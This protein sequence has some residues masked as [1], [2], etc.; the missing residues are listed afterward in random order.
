MQFGK[1]FAS[2]FSERGNDILFN[3]RDPDIDIILLTDPRRDSRSSS[4]TD[5]DVAYY[6]TN[7]N[8]RSIVVQRVNDSNTSRNSNF[9]S[10]RLAFA[11]HCA[12]Q[13]VFV[14]NWLKSDYEKD[15]FSFI[16]PVVIHNGADRK[17]FHG[18]GG[19]IWDGN[20]RLRVVTHHWSTNWKKGFDVYREIDAL[21]GEQPYSELFEFTFVGRVPE[22]MQFRH[23]RVVDPLTGSHLADELRTHHVYVSASIGEAAGMHYIEAALC[24]LPVLYRQSGSLPEYCSDFGSAFDE[25]AISTGLLNTRH[26]YSRLKANMSEYPYDAVRCCGSYDRLF[27]ELL[28][29]RDDVLTRRRWTLLNSWIFRSC[30]RVLDTVIK[31]HDRLVHLRS[32][33][34]N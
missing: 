30:S 11:N 26:N 28:A 25:G 16:E 6:L 21:L 15:G 12:H 33:S 5:A 8:A 27:R 20:E 34:R 29:K 19:R 17:V 2:Y 31:G 22:G 1:A 32:V 23:T 13:T 24:G 7:I 3:L 4:I 14:S 18:D 9:R 10:R